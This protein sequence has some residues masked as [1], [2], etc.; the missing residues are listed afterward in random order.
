MNKE[1]YYSDFDDLNRAIFELAKSLKE[2]NEKID[3]LTARVTELETVSGL[4]G[5]QPKQI[6]TE[7]TDDDVVLPDF[8]S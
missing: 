7:I 6:E 1:E 8:N 3:A 5:W 2:A 4:I